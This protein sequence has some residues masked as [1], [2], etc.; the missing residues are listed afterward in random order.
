M[1]SRHHLAE[2]LAERTLHVSDTGALANEVAGYL[3]LNGQTDQLESLMRDIMAYRAERGVVEAT[4][5]SANP[6]SGQD[7]EDIKNILKAEYP[8]AKQFTIDQ[9]QSPE[10][11]GGVKLNLPGEQLDLTVKS[12]VNKFKRLTT[13]QGA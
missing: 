7:V 13:S 1:S 2:V 4:A 8:H 10:V 9:E 3:L 11:V 6:L 12:Q 5:V